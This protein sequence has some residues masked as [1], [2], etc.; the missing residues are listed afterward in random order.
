LAGVTPFDADTFRKA[1][2]DE[3]R[4][5]IRETE[6]PKP[7]TRLQTLGEKLADVAKHRRTEP[8]ALGRLVRGDL[9]WIVMKCLE[10]DRQRRYETANG[11]ATD[12]A[13]HLNSEP[14]LARPPSNFYRFQ[15]MFRRHKLA[16]TAAGAVTA[17][18]VIGL[19]VSVWSLRVAVAAQKAAD[20]DRQKAQTEAD[21]SRQVAQFLEN[22]LNSIDPYDIEGRD[23]TLVR[24]VLD[25]TAKRMAQDLTNHPDLAESLHKLAGVL[26]EQDK[27]G[28]A[29]G[30]AREA[31]A[32]GRT[33]FGDE[34]PEVAH[35]L[36][37]LSLVL[38][39]QGKLAEAENVIREA[40]AM[41]KKLLGNDHLDA[42]NSLG[43]LS[44]VLAQEGKLDE[45]ENVVRETVAVMRNVLG[46][47]HL[48]LAFPLYDLAKAAFE[49]G[50]LSEAERLFREV[51]AIRKQHLVSGHPAT[52]A[53][54]S[55]LATVLRR[56][57]R[58]AEAEPLYR[59]C[60]A[61]REKRVPDAWYTF[62]TR[63]MLG[64]TLLGQKS[65]AEAAPLL[66]SGYDGMKQREYKIRDRSK[67][68]TEA[69]NSLVRLYE[70]TGPP[71]KVAEWKQKLAELDKTA[72]EKKVTG[73]GP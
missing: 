12:V 9:D 33:I 43:V 66:I 54:M 38:A 49:R 70:A 17:A 50:R 18:L 58:F 62:D 6:P 16:F 39:E 51:L 30:L 64:D 35:L 68:L 34:H 19:G 42:A 13:R 46:N 25:K 44:A 4:R 71:D 26:W 28:E 59:E 31:L 56:Q 72:V 20:A 36:S 23:I 21:R 29:E 32:R 41:Q 24:E 40:L 8:V 11:L 27:P 61:V 7:S 10:K 57:G 55:S 22:M 14:V 52:A 2:L 73:Q 48:S 5:M 63:A 37:L 1:G 60:L 53:A 47:E 15:K 3:I 67:V 45:S 65:Y 69:L